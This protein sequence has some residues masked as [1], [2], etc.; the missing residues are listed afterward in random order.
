MNYYSNPSLSH[1][2]LVVFL[3]R[4][5]NNVLLIQGG[6]QHPFLLRTSAV[7]MINGESVCKVASVPTSSV[8]PS[9][10]CLYF[11]GHLM[12]ALYCRCILFVF[13]LKHIVHS[14]AAM[15]SVTSPSLMSA[16]GRNSPFL[17][18]RE[19]NASPFSKSEVSS[20]LR[21]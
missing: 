14:G 11:A 8:Y 17:K 3:I 9:Q 19:R 4:R 12:K 15:D 2:I 6:S 20:G 7:N 16:G 13:L 18:F 21:H 5:A 1:L 10:C